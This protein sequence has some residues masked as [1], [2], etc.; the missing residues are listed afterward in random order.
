[1]VRY[2]LEDVSL[3]TPSRLIRSPYAIRMSRSGI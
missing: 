1:M 3:I 2:D